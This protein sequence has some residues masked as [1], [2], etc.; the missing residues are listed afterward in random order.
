VATARSVD[1]V[2]VAYDVTGR[3]E[4]TLVFVHGWAFDR[5]IWDAQV[6][7]FAAERRVVALDL[8]GH[9]ESGRGRGDWTMPAFGEDVRAVVDALDLSRVVLIGHSMGGPVVLEAAR[10]LPGRVAGLVLVDTLLD[11]ENRMPPERVEAILEGF[12]ADFASAAERYAREWLVLP[13]TD[14][15]LVE[16]I[17]ARVRAMDPAIGVSA[18]RNVWSYDPRPALREIRTPVRAVNAGRFPTNVEGMRRHAPQ[19]DAAVMDGVGHYP[20]LED[21][22]RFGRLLDQALRA[23]AEE[24]A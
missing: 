2:P 16:R 4:P 17:V 24:A 12:E 18:I 20:M 8:G 5:R 1:A 9:G 10:R 11:V 15:A 19:F 3:G 23:L 22:D 13:T 6:R 21:P 14:P 7:R